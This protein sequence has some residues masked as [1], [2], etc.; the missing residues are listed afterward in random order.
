M[1]CLEPNA[2]SYNIFNE[3]NMKQSFMMIIKGWLNQGVFVHII[4][5]KNK[6][7]IKDFLIRHQQ[8]IENDTTNIC[9]STVHE[10]RVSR[11]HTYEQERDM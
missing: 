2:A 9:F 3:L 4:L 5:K 8:I 6:W 10:N 7:N 1:Y 11:F